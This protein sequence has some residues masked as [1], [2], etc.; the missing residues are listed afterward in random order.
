MR[1]V[2]PI[3]PRPIN[4][5]LKNLNPGRTG[6]LI[7]GRTGTLLTIGENWDTLSKDLLCFNYFSRKPMTEACM[8][9]MIIPNVN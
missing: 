7:A 6:S 9:H 3:Y 1:D 4:I 5:L 2:T 8:L